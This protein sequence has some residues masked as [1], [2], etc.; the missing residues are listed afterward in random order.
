MASSSN[1]SK[2][3]YLLHVITFQSVTV[4]EISYIVLSADTF[5]KKSIFWPV[6]SCS[7]ALKYIPKK[8]K[9]FK[10]S[11]QIL[12][13]ISFLLRNHLLQNMTIYLQETNVN[14]TIFGPNQFA[15]KG[16]DSNFEANIFQILQVA[17]NETS[18]L[19][20][21][22]C[23][24]IAQEIYNFIFYKFTKHYKVWCVYFTAGP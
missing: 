6:R 7:N 13:N 8:I 3:H 19:H 10:F 21:A 22:I 20:S 16:C 23:S 24:W 1:V 11:E 9:N 14:C 18:T 2:V 12:K 5:L 4:K 17:T 15:H